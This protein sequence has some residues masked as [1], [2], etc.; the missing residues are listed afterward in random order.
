MRRFGYDHRLASRSL[1]LAWHSTAPPGYTYYKRNVL[2]TREVN[3]LMASYSS[4]YVCYSYSAPSSS[5]SCSSFISSSSFC[6]LI[7]P[8]PFLLGPYRLFTS[9]FFVLLDASIYHLVLSS[10]SCLYVRPSFLLLLLHHP[11]FLPPLLPPLHYLFFLVFLLPLPRL[12]PRPILLI[13][14]ITGVLL[15]LSRPLL[16]FSFLLYL[17]PFSFFVWSHCVSIA[18]VTSL[19]FRCHITVQ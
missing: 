15:F 3:T 1:T 10:F 7:H 5:T 17:A 8:N 11:L 14:P 18:P 12:L 13:L 16:L 9:F 6:L 4:S 19:T 2:F